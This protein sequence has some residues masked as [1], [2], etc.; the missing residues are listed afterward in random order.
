MALLLPG[1][2][3]GCGA[4]GGGGLPWCDGGGSGDWGGCSSFRLLAPRLSHPIPD[5]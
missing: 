4:G 2:R 5:T 1:C 3:G